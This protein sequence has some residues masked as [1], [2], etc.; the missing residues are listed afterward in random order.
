MALPWKGGICMEIAQRRELWLHTHFVTDCVRLSQ[1]QGRDIEA[2]LL[3]V[4]HQQHIVYGI[5]SEE[6]RHDS[7]IRIVLECI[8]LRSVLEQ[9]E[10]ALRHIIAPIPAKPTP[11]QTVRATTY[12]HPTRS[13]IVEPRETT[14]G[15]TRRASK[16]APGG[17]ACTITL[18]NRYIG[19]LMCREDAYEPARHPGGPAADCP[20]RRRNTLSHRRTRLCCNDHCPT[21]VAYGRGSAVRSCLDPWP[22]RSWRHGR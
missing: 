2:A 7:G 20:E 12:R 11:M 16:W 18:I 21:G 4:L 3:P 14:R 8:P 15:K 6:S 17:K 9:I 22:V 10:T 1:A 19:N 13:P 5:H